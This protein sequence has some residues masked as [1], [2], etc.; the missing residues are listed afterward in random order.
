MTAVEQ[1]DYVEKWLAG[2]KGKL[3]TADDLYMA[4][5]NP[6]HV[7]KPSD[8]VLYTLPSGLANKG[9]C[10]GHK[11]GYC[12]NYGLD[13]NN[14]NKLKKGEE[15]AVIRNVLNKGLKCINVR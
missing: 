9:E 5:F 3:N 4:V 11:D 8:F 7:G 12:L 13:K 2:K 15:G 10:K 14:D 1:L 6:A